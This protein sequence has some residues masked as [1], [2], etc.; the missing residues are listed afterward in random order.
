MLHRAI[1]WLY[2]IWNGIK[3]ENVSNSACQ[4][5]C[6]PTHTS[7]L[8]L[9]NVTFVIL[10][11]VIT[12]IWWQLELVTPPPL[13][14]Y[15]LGFGKD[16]DV[17]QKA[18]Q[19]NSFHVGKRYTINGTFTFT[20]MC[21]ALL[22][23]I[24]LP[25]FFFKKNHERWSLSDYI[26]LIYLHD[27]F[28]VIRRC[29]NITVSCRPVPAFSYSGT[30]L[31]CQHNSDISYK[32]EPTHWLRLFVNV[33]AWCNSVTFIESSSFFTPLTSVYKKLLTESY[34]PG[35]PYI[36]L[37]PKSLSL[38]FNTINFDLSLVN[39]L[40]RKRVELFFSLQRVDWLQNINDSIAWE[41][42]WENEECD[43]QLVQICHSAGCRTLCN[44]NRI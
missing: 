42:S 31:D 10:S 26:S 43:A 18:N 35:L 15:M 44:G 14:N 22:I 34:L 13:S 37:F 3:S 40:G 6:F 38:M 41:E 39:C 7:L 5:S 27:V 23:F 9:Y 25:K 21:T 17:S 29:G 2:F 16:N 24:Y 33:F 20:D 4:R 8:L 32:N 19:F 11:K 12:M 30:L 1:F 28:N 36:Y